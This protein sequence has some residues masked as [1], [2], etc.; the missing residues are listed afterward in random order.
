MIAGSIHVLRRRASVLNRN[1]GAR[2][3]NGTV[4]AGTDYFTD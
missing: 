2:S 3:G 4:A 1:R